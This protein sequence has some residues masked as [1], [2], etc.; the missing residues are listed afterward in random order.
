M[1]IR[2]HFVQVIQKSRNILYIVLH[3]EYEAMDGE[4]QNDT[5]KFKFLN[6]GITNYPLNIPFFSVP[7]RCIILSCV[8]QAFDCIF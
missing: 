6:S 4:R 1:S 2:F 7:P 5:L 8:A 3:A